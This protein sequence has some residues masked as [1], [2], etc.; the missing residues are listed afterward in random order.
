MDEMMEKA[1]RFET[2]WVDPETDG[3]GVAEFTLYP[4]P[5]RGEG[6]EGSA[7]VYLPPT[8]DEEQDERYPVLY[9]LHG[10]FAHSHQSLQGIERIDAAIRSGAMPATIVVAPQGLPI[11]WYVD[12]KDGAR[13]I[14]QIIAHDLVGFVDAAFRTI[15]DASGR[16]L[17]GF[18]M[19][20]YGALHL[21][22][23]HPRIFGSL[24]AIGPSILRDMTLEPPARTDNTFFG[25][26]DYYAALGPWSLALANAPELRDLS[27]IRL[28]GG[29]DDG[30]LATEIRAFADHMSALAIPHRF[31]ELEDVAH[32]YVAIMD[33]LGD[34][35]FAFWRGDEAQ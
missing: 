11:G 34:E 25:D 3:R 29:A 28:L 20:G 9:W 7:F 2:Q 8:Y 30:R 12:S 4:Q 27:R 26:T 18:S 19:G 14:E 5:S 16:A 1:R 15:P 21:G 6:A 10:G 33:A 35:Y 24:S 22:L 17:E 23:K 31:Q 32:D 13:P